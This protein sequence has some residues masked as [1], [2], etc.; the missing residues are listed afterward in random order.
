MSDLFST[1]EDH[2]HGALFAGVKHSI[3]NPRMK[4]CISNTGPLAGIQRVDREGTKKPLWR[5]GWGNKTK[6]YYKREDAREA[7]RNANRYF[8]L[9]TDSELRDEV[10]PHWVTRVEYR[11]HESEDIFP[12]DAE[13]DRFFADW[14][15]AIKQ[16]LPNAEVVFVPNADEPHGLVATVRFP[17]T[18]AVAWAE[19]PRL[20]CADFWRVMPPI[21]EYGA[22]VSK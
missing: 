14:T 7:W 11:L 19:M 18:G 17:M 20:F 1:N 6:T 10:D 3:P 16:G 22:V 8:I 13:R 21:A 15:A 4:R 2:K 5:V 12:S 9:A